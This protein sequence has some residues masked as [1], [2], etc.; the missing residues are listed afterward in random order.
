MTKK[1]YM[2][3]SKAFAVVAKNVECDP[4]TFDYCIQEVSKVFL[5][6]NPRFCMRTFLNA[7]LQ[8]TKN[9]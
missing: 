8:E 3:F 1:D 2:A 9:G 7:V 4:K 6:D 5:H